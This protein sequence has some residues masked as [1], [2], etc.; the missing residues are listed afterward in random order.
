MEYV[1]VAAV[2]TFP[3]TG[4]CEAEVKLF[5]PV[6]EYDAPPSVVAVKL[7]AAPEQTGEL[8][9]KPGGDGGGFTVTDA[10]PTEPVQPFAAAV[11]E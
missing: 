11:T 4:F 9:P 6:Q 2:E 1:P 3:I 7:S 8:L 10:I 5:G